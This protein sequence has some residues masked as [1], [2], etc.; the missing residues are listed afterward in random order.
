MSQ[1][2]VFSLPRCSIFPEKNR[3][4]KE[5]CV[6]LSK[7]VIL[8]NTTK[9]KFLVFFRFEQAVSGSHVGPSFYNSSANSR[10]RRGLKVLRFSVTAVP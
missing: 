6:L 10:V 2:Y 7:Q 8:I 1:R 3:G 5:A 9:V 4:T